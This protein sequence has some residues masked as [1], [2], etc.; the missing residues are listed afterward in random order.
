MIIVSAGTMI[1]LDE[2]LP[3]SSWIAMFFFTGFGQGI[4]LMSLVACIQAAS[5]S[6]DVA[7]AAAMYTLVRTFGMVV[8]VAI[9]GTVFQN[10]MA[11]HLR[12]LGLPIEVAKN[13]EAFVTQL[14]AMS[15]A[16]PT[17]ELF[18]LAYSRSFVN[19]WEVL[20]GIAGLGGLASVFIKELSMDK[21]LD[22]EHVVIVRQSVVPGD[23]VAV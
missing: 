21:E 14:M 17:K 19:L 5:P 13:S 2:S 7:Y 18:K 9:G 1:M 3:S 11:A 4:I 12:E 16:D 22:T 8:G 6:K 20:V 10:C 23:G 15:D